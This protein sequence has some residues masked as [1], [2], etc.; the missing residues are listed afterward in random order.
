MAGMF[1]SA[2]SLRNLR[3]FEKMAEVNIMLRH[4]AW[5][6]VMAAGLAAPAQAGDQEEANRLFVRAAQMWNDLVLEAPFGGQEAPPT[7]ELAE[8]YLEAFG[9]IRLLLV[10][11][12]D[13]HPGSDLAVRLVIGEDIGPL[14]LPKMDL[15]IQGLEQEYDCLREHGLPCDELEARPFEGHGNRAAPPLTLTRLPGEPGFDNDILRDGRA[16]IVHFW[17]S[18][19]APSRISNLYLLDLSDDGWPVYGIAYKDSLEDV[20]AF[21]E[22]T[23]NPFSGLM[24]DS[25]TTAI[26]WGIYG[27]PQTAVLSGDGTLVFEV[28][29][30]LTRDDVPEVAAAL[31]D[32]AARSDGTLD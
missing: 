28:M 20:R 26:D 9:T 11:I 14:S 13:D 27:V 32:A 21:L 23:G 19:A 30:P 8:D 29:G 24:M 4:F 16:K 12:V 22:E 17:S 2:Q 10:S 3:G 7:A 1:W 25:G 5:S 31:S 18:W 15:Y 6:A